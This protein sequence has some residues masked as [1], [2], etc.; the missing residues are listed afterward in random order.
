MA[1]LYG[2][3]ITNFVCQR[4]L[5]PFRLAPCSTPACDYNQDQRQTKYARDVASPGGQGERARGMGNCARLR[6]VRAKR[7]RLVLFFH[8]RGFPGR[9]LG[10]FG[11]RP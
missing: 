11:A 3:G 4:S 1:R 9:S 7:G 5:G 2:D 10:A 6:A 8:N